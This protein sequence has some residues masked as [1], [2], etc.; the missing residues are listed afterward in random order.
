MMISF[1]NDFSRDVI[2]FDF[3]GLYFL[4]EFDL[5]L[6]LWGTILI[7]LFRLLVMFHKQSK[8]RGIKQKQCHL[9]S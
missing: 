9:D 2:G 6:G 4:S 5:N 1:V 3:D 8:N 7:R